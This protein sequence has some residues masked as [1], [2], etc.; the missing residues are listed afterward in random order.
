M[1][2]IYTCR[3]NEEV[4][5]ICF[6]FVELRRSVWYLKT[7]AFFVYKNYFQ[8]YMNSRRPRSD[9]KITKYYVI[10]T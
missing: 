9:A 4:H 2:K 6:Q 3:L 5:K 10:H 7:L 1:S 8:N